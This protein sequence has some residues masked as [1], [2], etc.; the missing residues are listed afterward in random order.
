MKTLDQQIEEQTKLIEELENSYPE[1]V[2]KMYSDEN[3]KWHIHHTKVR[4]AYWKRRMLIAEK[5]GLNEEQTA[6]I[7]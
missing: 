2:G 4:D 5:K 3:Y 1:L 6:R 7:Y